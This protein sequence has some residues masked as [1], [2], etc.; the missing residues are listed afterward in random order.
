MIERG[1][2]TFVEVGQALREI[3]DDRLYR[4]EYETFEEYV[5]KRWE[6]GQSRAYQFIDAA[7][8]VESL[9]SSTIVELLPSNEAQIRPLSILQT[10]QQPQVW[11]EAVSTAPN[12]KVTAAHVAATVQ[13][14]QNQVAL[15]EAW[16][17]QE[18]EDTGEC[19]SAPA[20]SSKSKLDQLLN[21]SASIKDWAR[22]VQRRIAKTLELQ[23]V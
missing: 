13:K 19:D 20:V 6:M 11:Q 21:S 22:T 15:E 9:K 16:Q 17:N 4:A 5:E 23:P 14:H 1:L 8:I 10:E 2:K 18:D 12:G 3:R 7:Q